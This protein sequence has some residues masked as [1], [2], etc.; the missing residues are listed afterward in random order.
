MGLIGLAKGDMRAAVQMLQSVS[1][2]YDEINGENLL[3]VSDAVPDATIEDF[4]RRCLDARTAK[5]VISLVDEFFLKGYSGPPVL[6]KILDLAW[7]LDSVSELN[8]ARVATQISR[9]EENL[10][11]GCNEKMQ[12]V[13]LMVQLRFLLN[14]GESEDSEAPA[15]REARSDPKPVSGGEPGSGSGC[16]AEGD[17]EFEDSEAPPLCEP[18]SDP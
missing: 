9:A 18:R 8:L 11:D 10:I 7:E 2:F 16:T 17:A 1:R 3:E 15:L 6:E 12:M 13:V 4:F 5:G 14:G